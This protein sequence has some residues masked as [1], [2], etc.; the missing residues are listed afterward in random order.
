MDLVREIL[1]RPARSFALGDDDI[2]QLV[3]TLTGYGRDGDQIGEIVQFGVGLQFGE[4]RLLARD[5][6]DLV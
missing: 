3:Q 1:E 6:I 4:P 5:T 2:L